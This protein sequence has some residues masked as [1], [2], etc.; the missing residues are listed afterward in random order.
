M[1]IEMRVQEV[2]GGGFERL[3]NVLQSHK[4][5]SAAP[6]P[7]LSLDIMHATGVRETIDQTPGVPAKPSQFLRKQRGGDL[8]VPTPSGYDVRFQV[9]TEQEASADASPAH[10]YRHKQRFTFV[11]KKLFKF[12]L[13]RVK[14]GPTHEAALQADTTFEVEIEF[15]GQEQEV[16]AQKGPG[17][18][19]DS[20]LMKAADALHHLVEGGSSNSGPG[21]RKRS[22]HGNGPLQECDEVALADGTE[23]LLEPS[24]HGLPPRFSGEMPA[25]LCKWLY[26]HAEPKEGR[27]VVMSE[28]AS[29]GQ[30]RYPLFYFVGSV[31]AS[32][33]RL[34]D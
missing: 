24:G 19:A 28:P 15:C 5:W 3:L 10:L 12:E 34:R 31:P 25:A 6:P 2:G 23:V 8:K 22:T 13:T 32:S 20:L 27:V 11:H 26:S 14:Q 33:V 21:K 9:S 29:I 18:L 16:L 1:E 7:A 30:E 4:G 17:Y